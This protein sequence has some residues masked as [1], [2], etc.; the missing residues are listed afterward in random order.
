MNDTKF[1]D[2]NDTKVA[3]INDTKFEDINDTKV[4]GN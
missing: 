1:E 3:G 2:I 4:A